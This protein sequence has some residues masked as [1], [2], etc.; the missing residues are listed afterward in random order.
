MTVKNRLGLI[1]D[2]IYRKFI[3]I[4]SIIYEF[5]VIR[6]RLKRQ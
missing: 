4:F 3:F 2:K 1:Q 5:P 6:K